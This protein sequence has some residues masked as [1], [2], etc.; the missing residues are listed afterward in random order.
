MDPDTNPVKVRFV[1]SIPSRITPLPPTFRRDRDSADE[2]SNRKEDPEVE[3][4][5]DIFASHLSSGNLFPDY[6]ITSHGDPGGFVCYASPKFGDVILEIPKH[7]DEEGGRGLFAHYLW[8]AAAAAAAGIE[9]ASD[10]EETADKVGM[11][12]KTCGSDSRWWDV[13]GLRVLEVGAGKVHC[14]VFVH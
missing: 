1:P 6:A 4:P 5:I 10:I 3:D 2:L 7:P 11:M 9:W 8:T 13:R 14:S 12:T